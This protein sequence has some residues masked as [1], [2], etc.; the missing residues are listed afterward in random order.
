MVSPVPYTIELGSHEVIHGKATTVNLAATAIQ[1][2]VTEYLA[3]QGPAPVR[4]MIFTDGAWE[5]LAVDTQSILQGIQNRWVERELAGMMTDEL[6]AN[7]SAAY[8]A[9]PAAVREKY[10]FVD[11]DQYNHAI[12]AF[13]TANPVPSVAALENFLTGFVA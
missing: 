13:L 11:G 1:R 3:E 5:E 2:T 8:E 4:A 7:V 10:E 9:L 12:L 6:T